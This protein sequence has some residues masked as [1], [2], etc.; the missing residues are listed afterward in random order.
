[1]GEMKRRSV[2]T[3]PMRKNCSRSWLKMQNESS[4]PRKSE[5]IS[6]EGGLGS[7]ISNTPLPE[8]FDAGGT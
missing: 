6:L 1:M 3:F 8:D 5:F 2:L 4:T 7:L